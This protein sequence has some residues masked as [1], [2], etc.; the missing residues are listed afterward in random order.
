MGLQATSVLAAITVQLAQQLQCN[1]HLEPS[2]PTRGHLIHLIAR[3][4]FPVNTV[5]L[6]DFHR[7]LDLVPLVTIARLVH[8]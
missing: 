2:Y 6:V 7:Q 8:Q 1:A 5:V 4:A 3:A